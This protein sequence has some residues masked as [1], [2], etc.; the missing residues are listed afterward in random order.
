MEAIADFLKKE[1]ERD[2]WQYASALQE[3]ACERLG[4]LIKQD[5]WSKVQRDTLG[6]NANSRK[7]NA[8]KLQTSAF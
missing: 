6:W 3:K 8:S 1:K 7:L 4:G 5:A 2:T